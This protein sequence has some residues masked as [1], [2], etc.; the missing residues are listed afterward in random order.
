MSKTT[1]IY[2]YLVSMNRGVIQTHTQHSTITVDT[3]YR[4]V[5]CIKAEG[6]I[7]DTV[8]TETEPDGREE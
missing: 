4:V 1:A 7:E 5:V 8:C 6:C 3:T 2:L